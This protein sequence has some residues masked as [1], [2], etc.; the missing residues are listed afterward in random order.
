MPDIRP[1]APKPAESNP[2][3]A[4]EVRAGE[5]LVVG[6]SYNQAVTNLID[7]GFG[8]E[9]VEKAMKAAFNNP[10]RATDYLINVIYHLLLGNTRYTSRYANATHGST[11]NASS[12]ISPTSSISPS[13]NAIRSSWIN[14]R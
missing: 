7:M 1:E 5:G 9:E 8:K 6:E 10:E 2:S 11:T 12:P 3:S 13:A 4:P 14:G